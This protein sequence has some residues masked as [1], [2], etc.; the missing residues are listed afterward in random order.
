MVA[1][2]AL[3]NFARAF[4]ILIKRLVLAALKNIWYVLPDYTLKTIYFLNVGCSFLLFC[5]LFGRIDLE[6]SSSSANF[7][8]F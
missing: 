2:N 7:P 6:K 8:Y 3:A 4:F 1:P 5:V